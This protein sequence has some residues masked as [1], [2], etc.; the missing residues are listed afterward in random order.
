MPTDCSQFESHLELCLTLELPLV[1]VITKLDVTG[2]TLLRSTLNRILTILKAAHR[3][4]FVLPS[5][6]EVTPE[7]GSPHC[8]TLH[9]MAEA[10]R[11]LAS[12]SPNYST[13]VPIIL[14]SAVTGRGIGT[15]HAL[16]RQLPIL[17]SDDIGLLP[18]GG[19]L[20]AVRQTVF[21]I[22]EVFGASS[23]DA[24]TLHDGRQTLD[25]FVLGGYLADGLLTVG[26]ELV[27]GP[28][29]AKIGHLAT[30]NATSVPTKYVVTEGS[31]SAPSTPRGIGVPS[32]PSSASATPF[33]CTV[34]VVSIRDRRLPVQRLETDHYGTAGVV[35]TDDCAHIDV[36]TH[37]D[38]SKI[39]KGMVMTHPLQS[40][41]SAYHGFTAAFAA[42]H[43]TRFSLGVSVA[44]YI[45]SIRASATVTSIS[46]DSTEA[47][48]SMQAVFYFTSSYEFFRCNDRVLILPDKVDNGAIGLGG[49]MGTIMEGLQ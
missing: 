32:D 15:L 43:S 10:K 6:P 42:Q 21:N 23:A 20:G 19:A 14:T 33:W 7:S 47:S 25:G 2:V 3:R 27:L 30:S 49:V 45:N 34:R 24:I 8:P 48:N 46:V 29:L 36:S 35:F 16:L 4:P 22:D 17:R 13:L 5:Q 28:F 9:D 40:P 26:D 18:D 37:V 1:V 41:P 12:G 44:V 11:V 31:D 38:V 39:R